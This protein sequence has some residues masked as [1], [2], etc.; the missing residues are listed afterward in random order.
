MPWAMC[1][2][3]RKTEVVPALIKL[4]IILHFEEVG[5]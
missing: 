2:D 4:T 5:I 1:G 3:M